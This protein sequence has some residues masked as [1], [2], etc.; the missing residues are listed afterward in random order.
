MRYDVNIAFSECVPRSQKKENESTEWI[1]RKRK[2]ERENKEKKWS[3]KRIIILR[4]KVHDFFK[5]PTHHMTRPVSILRGV[6]IYLSGT[7]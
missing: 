2:R 1:K 7:R 4:E 3:L 6:Q 5:A